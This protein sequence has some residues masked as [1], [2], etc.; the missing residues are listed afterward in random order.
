VP[1]PASRP[2]ASPPPAF[3]GLPIGLDA[4]SGDEAAVGEAGGNDALARTEGTPEATVL[5]GGARPEGPGSDG[6]VDGRVAA[7]VRGGEGSGGGEAEPAKEASVSTAKP[8]C[9]E[10]GR[11]R[12]A[13]TSLS[14]LRVHSC[15]KVSP[16]PWLGLGLGF[17]F[18]FGFG[19]GL[20]LGLGFGLG[21]GP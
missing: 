15:S 3:C 10:S 5:T 11:P 16:G 6:A 7:S 21:L 18:G 8:I 12:M 2:L 13:A 4:P 17:G 1:A 20:G 19:L 9:D 14:T